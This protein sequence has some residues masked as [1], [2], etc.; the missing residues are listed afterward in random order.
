MEL[1][2]C[3]RGFV[4]VVWERL[5]GNHLNFF[6]FISHQLLFIITKKK[7]LFSYLREGV[8]KQGQNLFQTTQCVLS[9]TFCTSIVRL[10]IYIYIFEIIYCFI[11]LFTVFRY[12]SFKKEKCQLYHLIINIF[13]NKWFWPLV[14]ND[15]QDLWILLR[16][17]KWTVAP[18]IFGVCH[19]YKSFCMV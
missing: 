10:Y 4:G 9:N 18:L 2:Q 12:M 7:K 19:N 15:F 13:M 11:C 8:V 14:I 17:R 3:E 1:T 5:W 16:F 6:Y